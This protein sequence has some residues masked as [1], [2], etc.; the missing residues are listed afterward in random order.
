MKKILLFCLF[1]PLLSIAQDNGEV[2][3]I[4]TQYIPYQDSLFL[5]QTVKILNYGIDGVNDTLRSYSA[6][7]DT[8]GLISQERNAILNATNRAAAVMRNAFDFRTAVN[9]YNA[10]KTLL[11]LVGVSLDELVVAT[12]LTQYRGRYR[13][14]NG[15]T[16]FDVNIDAHPTRAD[17]L[18]AT[19]TNNEG[20][21]NVVV[22]GRWFW[23]INLGNG[24][25]PVVI[26]DGKP[27]DRP[28]FRSPTFA[29]PTFIAAPDAIRIVK[30]Q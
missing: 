12:Y 21:F 16:V 20:V 8:A 23:R 29:I 4:T 17:L 18:R 13:I 30:I 9:E 26:W 14:T 2:I 5:T 27:G 6:P 22:Y 3:S 15:A 28:I 24:Y 7:I 10:K 1:L 25:N 11:A 19:G